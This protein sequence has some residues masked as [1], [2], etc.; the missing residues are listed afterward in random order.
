MSTHRRIDRHIHIV[1]IAPG[2]RIIGSG[3]ESNGKWCHA[4][5]MPNR[6]D[7]DA[8]VS[9]VAE[10]QEGLITSAQLA[11]IGV[12]RSTIQRRNQLGGL[13][14]RVLPGVHLVSGSLEDR[15]RNQA[16][17]L[18]CGDG[19]VLTGLGALR[20]MGLKTMERQVTGS[21]DVHVLIPAGRRRLSTGF[22]VVERTI[23]MPNPQCVAGFPTASSAR[24]I[25]DA[26]HRA[27][28]RSDVLALVT[29]A[30]RNGL[31]ELA[32]L[33]RELSYGTRRGTRLL[34]EAI[35]HASSGSW[36]GPEA[37]LRTGV[38]RSTLPEPLWNAMLQTPSGRILAIVDG[39]YEDVGLALEV[40]SRAYH[41]SGLDWEKTLD[42]SARLT[43]H[44]VVVMHFTP[45]RIWRDL[46]SVVSEIHQARREL[47]GRRIPDLRVTA[48]PR[49]SEWG[50]GGQDITTHSVHS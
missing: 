6:A 23:R 38:I 10:S 18:Y 27:T 47:M 50:P 1:H 45:S 26:G 41:S 11:Q 16:A 42:R 46:D 37:Q 43:S 48:S 36:S 8:A 34:R 31:V 22:A 21:P 32:D 13:W 15:Q 19:S 49:P 3:Q 4:L 20:L 25:I 5:G 12:S 35:E 14:N 7:F 44:G 40:D 9:R 24:A 30:A 28:S 2:V 17:L 29:D 33:E 39:Y